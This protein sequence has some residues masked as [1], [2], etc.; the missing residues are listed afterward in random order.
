[1]EITSVFLKNVKSYE[2]QSFDLSQGLTAIAGENG[3]GKSTIVEA[4]GYALFG[5]AGGPLAGFIREGERASEIRLG[6]ISPL[7]G[8]EYES[9]RSLRMSAK[10]RYGHRHVQA[11]GR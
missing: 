8:R 3:A 6:F 7:D 1:M 4:V 9:V 2:E 10:D 5:F 11:A